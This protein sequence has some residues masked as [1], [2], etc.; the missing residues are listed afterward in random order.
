M[1]LFNK[2]HPVAG[3]RNHKQEKGDRKALSLL[4][5]VISLD[6]PQVSYVFN[7]SITMLQV[8]AAMHC[9]FFYYLLHKLL[10]DVNRS[11]IHSIMQGLKLVL[12]S[13]TTL[14]TDCNMWEHCN[15]EW[16]IKVNRSNY[17]AYAFNSQNIIK[18]NLKVDT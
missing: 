2:M 9:L 15:N 18:L 12:S 3:D 5:P 13:R 16:E 1:L 8:Q 14:L 17:I 6:T 7:F 4:I 10:Q 11:N